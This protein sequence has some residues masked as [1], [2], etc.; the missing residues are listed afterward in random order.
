[1]TTTP[2]SADTPPDALK[3]WPLNARVWY[4]RSTDE[5]VLEIE[6]TINDTNMVCRHT[7][8]PSVAVEDVP[9]LPTLY[10]T[11]T[12][13]AMPEG[14]EGELRHGDWVRLSTLFDKGGANLWFDQDRRINEFLK[15]RLAETRGDQ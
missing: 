4:R 14:G 2:A 6:G 1:M 5:W 7:Q 10:A 3:A 9:G 11:P 12:I 13:E 8:P 15:A